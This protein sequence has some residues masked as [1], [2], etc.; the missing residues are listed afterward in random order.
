MSVYR[1]QMQSSMGIKKGLAKVQ[2]R[3]NQIVLELLGGE[4][5]FD[6]EFVQEHAFQMNGS[7]QTAMHTLPAR[8]SGSVSDDRLCAVL[9]TEQGSFPIEGT[10]EEDTPL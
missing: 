2:R 1:I 10:L 6:G 7:L 9:H 3:D 4:N 8:L 5:L